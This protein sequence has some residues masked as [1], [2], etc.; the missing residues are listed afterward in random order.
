[1]QTEDGPEMTLSDGGIS[2]GTLP[3]SNVTREQM[4]TMFYRYAS[5]LSG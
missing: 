1:M 5:A 4:V 2:D 3:D